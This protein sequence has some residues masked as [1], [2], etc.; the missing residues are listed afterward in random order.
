MNGLYKPKTGNYDNSDMTWTWHWPHL[1]CLYRLND[2]CVK[3]DVCKCQSCC[4]KVCSQKSTSWVKN[5][6]VR[7]FSPAPSHTSLYLGVSQYNC[8]FLLVTTEQSSYIDIIW[9]VSLASDVTTTAARWR[10]SLKGNYRSFLATEF[11][12]FSGFLLLL[13]NRLV[14]FQTTKFMHTIPSPPAWVFRS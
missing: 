6:Q 5:I 10:L 13:F 12:T 7:T 14:H 2:T 1:V 9:T 4:F 3:G 8:N 11:M